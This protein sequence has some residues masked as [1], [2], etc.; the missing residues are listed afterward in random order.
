MM[1]IMSTAGAAQLLGVS[2]GT[3]R[4]W[5]YMDQGPRSF[6]VGRHVKYRREDVEAWLENQMATTARGGVTERPDG[7]GAR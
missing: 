5:R 3:L 6:R 7:G 2:E 1:D 4:Y